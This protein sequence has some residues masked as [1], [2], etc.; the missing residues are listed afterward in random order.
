MAPLPTP[1]SLAKE[2]GIGQAAVP[3]VVAHPVAKPPGGTGGALPEALAPKPAAPDFTKHLQDN[4]HLDFVDRVLRPE[5]YPVINNPDGSYSSHLMSSAEVGGKNIA[6]PTIVR[7]PGQDALTKL[8]PDEAVKYAMKTGEHIAFPTAQEADQFASG[9]YKTAA[10]KLRQTTTAA[11]EGA[12]PLGHPPGQLPEALAP[13]RPGAPEAPAPP[14]Q[15]SWLG[16]LG[17]EAGRSVMR[18]LAGLEK[19]PRAILSMFGVKG[20]EGLAESGER[21]ERE[22][23]ESPD[24]AGSLTEHPSLLLKP[25]WWAAALPS[26]AVQ[27]LP[28]TLAALAAPAVGLTAEAGGMIAGGYIGVSAAAEAMMNWEKE[29]GTEL[30][31]V[32]KIVIGMGAGTAGAVLPGATMGR[33][34]LGKEVESEVAGQVVKKMAGGAAVPIEK[35]LTDIFGGKTG[36]A[37]ATRVVNVAMGSGSMAGFQL[38]ENSFEKFGYNPD[39]KLSQGVLESLI[40]GAMVSGVHSEIKLAKDRISKSMTD[41]SQAA[42]DAALDAWRKDLTEKLQAAH[43]EAQTNVANYYRGGKGAVIGEAP[44]EA[45][46]ILGP[47][48]KPARPD[49]LQVALAK[50]PTQRNALEKYWADQV[51]RGQET[52]AAG[53]TSAVTPRIIIPPREPGARTYEQEPTWHE[54]REKVESLGDMK[55]A[56]DLGNL[57][58]GNENSLANIFRATGPEPYPEISARVRELADKFDETG[59]PGDAKKLH[60]YLKANMKAIKGTYREPEIGKPVVEQP[61]GKAGL[62]T[63][64]PETTEPTPGAEKVSAEV[65]PAE[66][67]TPD[68]PMGKAGTNA[69]ITPAAEEIAQPRAAGEGVAG[70]KEPGPQIGEMFRTTMRNIDRPDLPNHEEYTVVEKGIDKTNDR[71]FIVGKDKNGSLTQFVANKDGSFDLKKTAP[72]DVP[73]EVGMPNSGATDAWRLGYMDAL[74]SVDRVRRPQP[75]GMTSAYNQGYKKALA[76]YPDLAPKPEAK[77]GGAKEPWEMTRDEFIKR[78]FSV[79]E[80]VNQPEEGRNLAGEISLKGTLEKNASTYYHEIAHS[81]INSSS[82]PKDLTKLLKEAYDTEG[83]PVRRFRKWDDIDEIAADVYGSFKTLKPGQFG[84]DQIH[85]PGWEKVVKKIDE[86]LADFHKYKIEQALAAGK[87]VPPEVLAD[88]PDLA[89]EAGGEGVV[90]PSV[91]AYRQKYGTTKGKK[92]EGLLTR[93]TGPNLAQIIRREGGIDPKYVKDYVKSGEMQKLGRTILKEGGRA[94]DDAFTELKASYPNEFLGIENADDMMRYFLDGRHERTIQQFNPENEEAVGDAYAEYDQR[95]LG[96]DDHEYEHYN[97][98]SDKEAEVYL[99]DTA[100]RR[101]KEQGFRPENLA[102][103]LRTAQGEL[104]EEEAAYG[105]QERAAIQGEPELASLDYEDLAER[106]GPTKYSV[107]EGLPEAL[108][109]SRRPTSKLATRLDQLQA[110]YPDIDRDKASTVLRALPD[111][112]NGQVANLAEDPELF[113]QVAQGGMTAAEQKRILDQAALPGEQKGLFGEPEG[114][115]LFRLT[116]ATGESPTKDWGK[117][118]IEKFYGSGVK[119]VESTAFPGVFEATFPSGIKGKIE[120]DGSVTINRADLQEGYGKEQLGPGETVAGEFYKIPAGFMATIAQGEG[121][122]TLAHELLGH[123]PFEVFATPREQEALLKKWGDREGVAN[124]LAREMRDFF[125]EGGKVGPALERGIFQRIK[126]FFTRI[127]DAIHPTW[128]S[129]LRKMQSGEMYER[130]GRRGGLPEALAPS[131]YRVRDEEGDEWTM[132]GGLRGRVVGN[133]KAAHEQ[134]KAAQNWLMSLAAPARASKAALGMAEVTA[135][136]QAESMT[137]KL[138]MQNIFK[139]FADKTPIRGDNTERIAQ[140]MDFLKIYEHDQKWES[141]VNDPVLKEFG[142]YYRQQERRTFQVMTMLNDAPHEIPNYMAHLWEQ[143]ERYQQIQA[144][145]MEGISEGRSMR[146]PD[147]YKL[148][149]TISDTPAGIAEGLVPKFDNLADTAMADQSAKQNRIAATKRIKW[150]EEKGHQKIVKDLKGGTYTVEDADGKEHTFNSPNDARRFTQANPGSGDFRFEPDVPQEWEPYP[151]GYGEI[152]AKVK[153][154]GGVMVPPEDKLTEEITGRKADEGPFS[155]GETGFR[156]VPKVD[157]WTRVGYRVGPPDVVR[158]MRD[159][160]SRGLSGNS[161]FEMYQ[162]GLHAIRYSQMALSLFHATFTS[163]NSVSVRAGEA[164]SDL[165]GL[166]TG[167]W[168]RVGRGLK[169]IALLPIAPYRDIQFGRSIDKMLMEHGVGIPGE[170]TNNADLKLA[171]Q[172][173]GGGLRP[174]GESRIIKVLA[175]HFEEAVQ[176]KG[177]AIWRRMTELL[178]GLSSPTMEVIVPFAKNGSTAFKFMREVERWGRNNPG[179]APTEE[180]IRNIAYECRQT[181]DFVYGRIARDNVAMNGY[182]RSLLTGVLQFP[183]WQM[184]TLGEGVR[185]VIGAKDIVGKVADMMRGREIRQLDMKDRQALQYVTGLL[186]TIGMA[187]GL[188]HWVFTGKKPETME[189]YF[190]PKT[191]EVNASGVE[192][193]LQLPSYFK[194]AMGATHH[195]FRTIG[196]KLAAPIH[197]LTDLIQNK[198]YWGTQIYD[199]HDWVGQRGIDVIKYI[200]KTS[201]PFALQSY[202]Q[203]AKGGPGRFGLSLLGVRPVPREYAETPAQ[204]VI[205]EYS[206]MER[207]SVTT[208]EVAAQKKLKSD[209]TKMA[210]EGDQEGFETAAS[211]AVSQGK[212]TTAQVKDIVNQSQA[213]PGMSR[214]IGLPLEWQVRAMKEASD[215]EKEKWAP[216]MLKKI[217][218]SKPEM[219]IR[220]REALVPLLKEMG[221]DPVAEVIQNMEMPPEALAGIDLTGIGIQKPGPELTGMDEVNE[222]ITEAIQKNLGKIGQPGKVGKPRK[223]TDKYA[224]LGL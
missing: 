28:I 163:I 11:P 89:P 4:R 167:D 66:A 45:Q 217:A 31:P 8:S 122:P 52:G 129:V 61:M 177:W 207:A 42:K 75:G 22:Y 220:N 112:E 39:R 64:T 32:K 21:M 155:L 162:N 101:A 54:L 96:L 142:R 196:A 189:D 149:R 82:V 161:A 102:A 128:K 182:L 130:E 44:P 100:A 138:R 186:F 48:G 192:E 63:P 109:P 23:P 19:A 198:D 71:G 25:R 212:L 154:P 216:F 20:A 86:G 93:R 108:A 222:A 77:A 13:T 204:G 113:R 92:P 118:D 50:D 187:G 59:E 153:R 95:R 51:I 157:V 148:L 5:K 151:G 137:E 150:I 144:Q 90:P 49:E 125:F 97:R 184:G 107:R 205:D 62:E 123:M 103:D 176:Q 18:G 41:K 143:N 85:K 47:D 33:M 201:A 15:P 221:L 65:T 57:L 114:G 106:Y 223:K 27:I 87:P 193:R 70:A 194:D 206:Q 199:P 119:V 46:Q 105:E 166:F 171:R 78:P 53:P 3:P 210:R 224:F 40:M 58:A 178:Q 211:E 94:P 56:Q 135:G 159:F 115:K 116:T 134:G 120:K 126:D 29:H 1:E 158:I 67:K 132:K 164:I 91:A 197:I 34:L 72:M 104:E 55:A 117:A 2:Y 30:S 195:P 190:F 209:L 68:Q 145:L 74:D 6:Y 88:Y 181:S 9:G 43:E 26:L 131:R 185:A 219:L 208:K 188:M 200:G 17:N 173:V 136:S 215:Y 203:G 214:F 16:E 10:E 191:G 110:E 202:G 38:I 121:L 83:D 179:I 76:D 98:L 111:A 73:E 183:T 69:A 218:D 81:I 60:D 146:G 160:L 37:L 140:V 127:L 139:P 169:D 124:G 170:E 141:K 152:W 80:N 180:D 165:G 172:L 24:V 174:E 79:E 99:N 213:P 175:S 168:R 36:S 133:V 7:K 14:S 12:Y 84:Y 147:Y 35:A 156:E